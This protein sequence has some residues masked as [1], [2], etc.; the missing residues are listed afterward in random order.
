MY[1]GRQ[2][3]KKIYWGKP[4]SKNLSKSLTFPSFGFL[5]KYTGLIAHAHKL[6]MMIYMRIYVQ[7]T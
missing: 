1:R 6:V 5:S 4:R 3:G 2:G 7:T